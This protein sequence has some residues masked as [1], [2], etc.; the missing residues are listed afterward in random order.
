M[1][2]F[3]KCNPKIYLFHQ[4]DKM[5]YRSQSEVNNECLIHNFNSHINKQYNYLNSLKLHTIFS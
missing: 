1:K 4:S 3:S 2:K 5:L